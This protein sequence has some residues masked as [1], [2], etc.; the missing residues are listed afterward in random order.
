MD[1]EELH[2]LKSVEFYAASVTAWYTSALEHDK[3]VFALSAGGIALLITLLTTAGIEE[4]LTLGLFCMAAIAFLITLGCLL[5][6][7]RLNQDYIERTL[8][9]GSLVLDP[10]LK[11]LDQTARWSFWLGVLFASAVGF[12]TAWTTFNKKLAD[13]EKTMAN[14]KP[15]QTQ[16]V[17]ALE[18]VHGAGTLNPDFTKSFHGAGG[19]QPTT[20]PTAST[21]SSTTTS[22]SSQQTSNSSSTSK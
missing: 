7:F 14:D 13:K 5:W 21:T 8:A 3:S 1:E 22:Q 18:S 9:T 12:S 15:A 11:R 16:T 17:P 2:Q 4:A 20:V 19:L 6:V 10:K